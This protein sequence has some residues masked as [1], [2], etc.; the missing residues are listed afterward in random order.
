[1]LIK[2]YKLKNQSYKKWPKVINWRNAVFCI[3]TKSFIFFINLYKEAQPP[4]GV[5][6]SANA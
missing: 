4:C 2:T 5:E 3:N 1:L 6:G